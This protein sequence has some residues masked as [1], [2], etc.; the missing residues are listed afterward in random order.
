MVYAEWW[1]R[2]LAFIVDML[3][4]WIPTILLLVVVD[5]SL[6]PGTV[7]PLTGELESGNRDAILLAVFAICY[8]VLVPAYFALSH[9]GEAG[10]TIG[11]RLLRIRVADQHRGS[12]IGIGRAFLRWVVTGLFWLLLYVPGILDLLW[13]I[14]DPERQSWHDKL[15]NSVV[16]TS[17]R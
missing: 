3:V 1:Q 2:M 11:K 14:W 17:P 8:F 12:P 16:V 10:W 13:P 4:V 15:V 9:G 5:S 6:G 7:D